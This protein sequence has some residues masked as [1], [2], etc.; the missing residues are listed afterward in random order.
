MLRPVSRCRQT[1]SALAYQWLF[2]G[3]NIPGATNATLLIANAQLTNAGVYAVVVSN[4]F[5]ELTSSNATLQVLPPNAPSIQVNGQLVAGTVSA[6]QPAIVTMS[7]GFPG[8]LIFYT[9]D[10]STP[11]INSAV[12]EEPITLNSS[13]VV[14][15]MALSADFSQTSFAPPVTVNVTPTYNLQTSV[16]G[17]GTVSLNPSNGPYVSNSLVMV[18]ATPG[19]HWAF[20]H[21]SGD[22]SGSQN[23]LSVTVNSQLNIQ[24][25]FTQT[26]Y[27]LDR[28]FPGRRQ[29]DGQRG[30]PYRRTHIIQSERLC[31]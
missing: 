11:N 31:L 24:A 3:T 4:V 22:A 6:L 7:G 23:P 19:A 17:S 27:F 18:T 15:A 8:G 21:W 28:H 5:T 2:Y 12:Y 20:N 16:A 13:A 9:L 30:R 10:G 29:R 25:V 26:A 14:S 1:G